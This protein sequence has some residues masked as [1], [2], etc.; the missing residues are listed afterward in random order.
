MTVTALS[1]PYPVESQGRC[2]DAS[3]WSVFFFNISVGRYKRFH[4][5]GLSYWQSQVTQT[6]SQLTVTMAV[7]SKKLAAQLAKVEF[8]TLLNSSCSP[9]HSKCLRRVSNIPL[10][11]PATLVRGILRR[12]EE[13]N[14]ACLS[15]VVGKA[16]APHGR[17]TNQ[18]QPQ[19]LSANCCCPEA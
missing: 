13:R 1:K 18:T 11:C 5:R 3:S 19:H 15:C 4:L 6:S 9:E 17:A 7:R 10:P 2:W 16:I 8:V 12:G 14:A